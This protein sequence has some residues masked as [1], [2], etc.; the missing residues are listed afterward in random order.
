MKKI[1]KQRNQNGFTLIE[2]MIVIAI[3]GLL[4]GFTLPQYKSYIER[5]EFSESVRIANKVKLGVGICLQTGDLKDCD[6]Y[7]EIGMVNPTKGVDNL[8][9]LDITADTAVITATSTILEDPTDAD[10]G[11]EFI[12]TPTDDAAR[13]VISWEISGSCQNAGLC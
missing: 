4:V 3:I 12:L 6:T 11:Y 13:G 8:H 2:L 10:S 5:T 1:K 7:D 9:S